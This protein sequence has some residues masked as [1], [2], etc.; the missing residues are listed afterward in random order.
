MESKE[1]YYLWTKLAEYIKPIDRDEALYALLNEL[2]EYDED[3]LEGFKEAIEEEEDNEALVIFNR[4]YKDN[5]I[6]EVEAW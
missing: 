3:Q 6:E 1:L 4:W 2:Y 5:G